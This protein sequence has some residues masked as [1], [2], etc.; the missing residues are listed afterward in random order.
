[1]SIESYYSH[2][3]LN[4]TSY[5]SDCEPINKITRQSVKCSAF[6]VSVCRP[7]HDVHSMILP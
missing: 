1:M 4:P 6:G 5:T 3:L 2:T 7:E